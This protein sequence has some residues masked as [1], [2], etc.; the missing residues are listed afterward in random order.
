MTAYTEMWPKSCTHCGGRGY[1]EYQ[2]HVGERWMGSMT[3][4]DDCDHCIGMGKCPRC[5]NYLPDAFYD[6]Y[7]LVLCPSCRWNPENPDYDPDWW[8]DDGMDYPDDH[9][10]IGDDTPDVDK[11]ERATDDDYPYALDD[12]NFDADRERRM[13]V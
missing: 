4:T 8:P 7:P 2:E 10:P 9:D 12:F 3:I 13:S 6:G 11:Y 5:G 1:V